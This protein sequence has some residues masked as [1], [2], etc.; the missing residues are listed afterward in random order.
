MKGVTR[1]MIDNTNVLIVNEHEAKQLIETFGEKIKMLRQK[2]IESLFEIFLNLKFIIVTLGA[3]GARV[4]GKMKGEFGDIVSKTI[5]ISRDNKFRKPVVDT[6]GAGDCFLGCLIAFWAN[7]KYCESF[8]QNTFSDQFVD[9]AKCVQIACDVA[10]ISVEGKGTQKSYP[11]FG[12]LAG[13][14]VEFWNPEINKKKN[15]IQVS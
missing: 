13:K 6:T 2:R 3:D 7:E 15:E 11:D 12:E 10:S 14:G 4:I 8:N 5:R 1:K 9:L